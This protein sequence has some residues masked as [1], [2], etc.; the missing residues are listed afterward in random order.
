MKIRILEQTEDPIQQIRSRYM[1]TNG[2]SI[3][4]YW[5]LNLTQENYL[6]TTIYYLHVYQE[7]FYPGLLGSF[8]NVMERLLDLNF[9]VKKE[10]LDII[11]TKALEI[12]RTPPFRTTSL[13][14][15]LA[16][17]EEVVF[18]EKLLPDTNSLLELLELSSDYD[19][20]PR[21]LYT[22]V[23]EILGLWKPSRRHKSQ[24][25]M[26]G[27]QESMFREPPRH[28]LIKHK[29][30]YINPF[31]EESELEEAIELPKSA[32]RLAQGF[33]LAAQLAGL[34]QSVTQPQTTP[35]LPTAAVHSSQR[36]L[37]TQNNDKEEEVAR[38]LMSVL[39]KTKEKRGT[40][41]LGGDEIRR[42]VRDLQRVLKSKNSR[43]ARE[44]F[45]E[46]SRLLATLGFKTKSPTRL[47]KH[48]GLEEK[49]SK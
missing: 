45:H 49:T 47:K 20:P 39:S 46:W 36:K 9:K 24:L 32:K 11:V 5:D 8:Q 26:F 2:R 21:K 17:L 1:K 3:P 10:L 41:S 33:I 40:G 18:K 13:K 48:L 14:T 27:I 42:M 38:R 15:F 44:F 7:D 37:P 6:T 4:S 43:Q 29:E 28:K 35:N 12:L 25:A 23:Q 19:S 22:L 31:V 16:T 30:E 34:S